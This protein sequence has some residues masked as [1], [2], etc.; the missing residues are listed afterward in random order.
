MLAMSPDMAA[1]C[2]SIGT[3]LAHRSGAADPFTG[4]GGG[5]LHE[6]WCCP[7][8]QQHRGHLQQGRAGAARPVARRA[9]RP[10][11]R[12]A[13]LQ[14]RRQVDH[15]QGGVEPAGAR[16]RRDDAWRRHLRR[17]G[18]ATARAARAGPH[19]HVPRHGGTADL[20]GPHRGGEPGR[21]DLCPP[22]SG[23]DRRPELRAGLRVLPAPV[24]AAAG[25]RRLPLGRRAAD[26]GDRARPG[27]PAQADAA[28]RALARA[29][30]HAGGGH[31]LDHRPHQRRAGRLDAAGRAERLGGARR[32]ALRL[33]HGDG[34][35]RDRWRRRAAGRGPGRARVLPR[36]RRRRRVE[37]LPR[38][39]ALQA[40]QA[41]AVMTPQRG[42][43]VDL[44]PLTMAQM[45]RDRS[46]A[47]PGAIAI[48]QK[49][50]GIWKPFTWRDYFE[51][52]ADVG[53][54]LAALGLS[55]GGHVGVLSE[56]RIEWVLAQMGAGLIGSITVGVYPTS[57]SV[58][59]AYVLAHADVEVVI[60]EDQEQSDKVLEALDRLPRLRRIVVIE[61]KGL[62]DTIETHGEL[63]V[64]FDELEARGREHR[65]AN[66]G[67][68]DQTL[69]AQTLD[70]IALMIY[71]SG[72]TGKPKGAMISYR[73]IRAVVP[74]IVDRLG[75]TSATT[76]L[77][78][79]PLC[80]VAQQ[81]LTTFVPLYLGSQVNF[82]ESIR[83]VQ[84]DLR[85]VAPT[86]F[87]GVPRI[88][89]KLHAAIHIRMQETGRLRR[90]LFEALVA[91]CAPFAEKSP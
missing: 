39:Q 2:A 47:T 88:W 34:Q 44:P 51:R 70:D 3:T 69:A 13:R 67:L 49:D 12:A 10:D 76:H 11:R 8:D 17:P 37:E 79:L 28:R 61:R 82:G 91:G 80:H 63:V 72:S 46:R 14:R 84:E 41:L 50:F 1:L 18:H 23:R 5:T 90:R 36:R 89:E 24:R 64:A 30:A 21:R 56:N 60:C 78:Y 15:A 83:T 57:P 38:D 33:H 68:V 22:R 55:P 71:T 48:R 62:R 31:L 29:V 25:H 19:G 32:G 59:V 9:A 4:S 58:E 75:L 86:M 53:H 16:G 43:P 85:E 77:S 42:S 81:M 66:P 27:G 20:P 74:G 54:G 52:S 73:N 65:R 6:G 40:P 35:D 26:A 45:L 7:G 87:L